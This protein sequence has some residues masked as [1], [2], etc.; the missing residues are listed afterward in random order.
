MKR[1]QQNITI[2]DSVANSAR[3]LSAV[4][5]SAQS[6]PANIGSMRDHPDGHGSS[7]AVVVLLFGPTHHGVATLAQAAQFGGGS[8]FHYP[9]FTK[10]SQSEVQRVKND[11]RHYLTRP[12]GLEAVLRVRTSRGISLEDF[13]GHFFLRA[14]VRSKGEGEGEGGRWQRL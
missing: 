8:F 6:G 1:A 12:L 7:R 5:G 14:Q 2:V 11:M 4:V 13:H 10:Q 9:A 3:H